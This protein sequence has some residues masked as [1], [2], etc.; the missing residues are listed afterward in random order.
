MKAEYRRAWLSELG[1]YVV[2]R[3]WFYLEERISIEQHAEAHK[4]AVFV[5]EAEAVDYC[6]YRNEMMHKMAR[7][8]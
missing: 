7:T 2:Y 4:I 3:H 5:Y 1:G 8:M 6:G